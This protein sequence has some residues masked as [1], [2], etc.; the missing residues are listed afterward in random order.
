M[1]IPPCRSRRHRLR[2]ARAN[3]LARLAASRPLPPPS[4]PAAPRG[5]RASVVPRPFRAATAAS[6][7]GVRAVAPDR[8]AYAQSRR[9][10][11][12]VIKV[13]AAITSG[14]ALA[15]ATLYRTPRTSA[16][17]LACRKQCGVSR[18]NPTAAS[19][20]GNHAPVRA[21]RRKVGD[22]AAEDS[23]VSGDSSPPAAP[24][25][26]PLAVGMADRHGTDRRSAIRRRRPPQ[27]RAARSPRGIR[28][29]TR[30]SQASYTAIP[31]SGRHH[32]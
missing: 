23:T 13:A 3:S 10:G 29:V 28:P 31:A 11:R 12:A 27:G 18:L 30:H 6:P 7:S 22:T 25:A 9:R 24:E 14:C 19:A 4:R 21:A 15:T 17:R 32:R 20:R 1:Y 16:D 5:F 26:V 2:R 8:R